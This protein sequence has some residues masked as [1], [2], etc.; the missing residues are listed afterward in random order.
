MGAVTVRYALLDEIPGQARARLRLHGPDTRRFL[1]G[2]LSADLAGVQ[3][4]HA[5]AAA[6][7][8]VKG[9]LVSELV[10]LP[11]PSEDEVHALVPVATA[12]A[13]LEHF[14]RHI[15]MD[16][17]EVESLGPVTAAVAWDDG[18]E[19]PTVPGG[20]DRAACEAFA[21]RHPAPGR[22]V[23]GTRPGVMAALAGF[24]AAGSEGWTAHRIATASPAWGQELHEGF[25]PPEVG[26][27]YAVS[28]D[29][30]CFLGQE[31]LARIHARGQVNRVLVRVHAARA[32][33]GAV[34]LASEERHDAGQWTS[35]V[36]TAEGVDGLA[37]VRRAVAQPGTVL[38]TADDEPIAVE[39]RS[40]PLGDDPGVG[41]RGQAGTI[42]LGGRR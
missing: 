20:D 38:H 22:L 13:L 33:T 9:K 25:F 7:C 42:K 3:P 31:P 34:A 21:T 6:L 1:Q 29:K 23:V 15:I 8:T 24:E 17:V 37:M 32:P 39:V 4:G 12:A 2:T 14:D 40:G 27:V 30:G 35:W 28:Y 11:G 10:L 26:F 16:E 41:G 18:D 5:V 19:P 36:A